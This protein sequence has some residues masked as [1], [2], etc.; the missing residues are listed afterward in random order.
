MKDSSS[1]LAAVFDGGG[2]NA[3]LSAAQRINVAQNADLK[4]IIVNIILEALK[5]VGILGVAVI[6]IAGFYLI[7]SLGG[8][9]GK[10]NAKKIILYAIIGIIVIILAR[11]IVL[12][13]LDIV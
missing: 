4:Q 3:G 1:L 12:F 9:T 7:L 11:V 6:I 13:I 2:V 10:E 5:F 8:E